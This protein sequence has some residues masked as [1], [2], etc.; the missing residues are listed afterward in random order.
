MANVI[1]RDLE[2]VNYLDKHLLKAL[3]NSGDTLII[4]GKEYQVRIDGSEILNPNH[5]VD[6]NYQ[7]LENEY[8]Y[9]LVVNDGREL[10]GPIHLLMNH[11]QEVQLTDYN[12]YLYIEENERYELMSL[13]N[14]ENG[15]ITVD[16]G[17]SYLFS[18]EYMAE[19]M[20]PHE[21]FAGLGGVAAV[22][23]L[24]YLLIKKRYW[25]W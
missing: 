8:G 21:V 4:Q 1:Y 23:L 7:I 9:L 19:S 10:P 11:D 22:M 20:V 13:V 25:F 17:G 18:Q 12:G 5:E 24:A 14:Q 2:D 15:E 3:N 6:L 16:E